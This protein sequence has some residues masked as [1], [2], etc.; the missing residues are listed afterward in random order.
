MRTIAWLA[1]VW[2]ALPLTPTVEAHRLPIKVYTTAN[3]MPRNSARCI[4]PDANGMLWICTSEGLVRFDGYQFRQFGPESGLPSRSIHDIVPS[5]KGGYWIVTDAGLCRLPEGSKIGQVCKPLEKPGQTGD[6]QSGGV[7][8]SPDGNVWIATQR[9]VFHVSADGRRLEPTPIVLPYERG[10]IRGFCQAP[11]GS[12]LVGTEFTIYR[13]NPGSMPEDISARF[14]GFE[15]VEQIVA[16]PDGNSLWMLSPHHLHRMSGFKSGAGQF[17]VDGFDLPPG[18][19]FSTMLFRRNGSLWLATPGISRVE[20]DPLGKVKEVER[21]T[22]Q[23]GLP[24]D[25]IDMLTED[26]QGNL[27]GVSGGYGVFRISDSGF[28]IHTAADGLVSDRIAAIFESKN[29]ELCILSSSVR[30]DPANLAV[31][32]GGRFETVRYG[33]PPGAMQSGWGWGQFGMQAHDGEWWFPSGDGLYRFASV[34]RARDLNGRM[35]EFYYDQKST[36]GATQIFRIFEDSRGDVWIS[37]LN[38]KNTLTQWKRSENAFHRWTRAE[39]WLGED[40]AAVEIRETHAGT[41]WAATD[42]AL[43]RLRGGRFEYIPAIPSSQVAYVR[44]MYV[45]R[46][47]RLWVATSRYG[48]FRCDDPEAANPVF[49]TYGPREGLSS[50]SVR[51]ITEDDAGYLYIGTVRG[52][53]RIDPNAPPGAYRIRHF[54]VAD[55]VPDSEQNVAFH[56]SRGRLWFGSLNGLAE[57]DPAKSR[58]LPPSLVY[59]TRLRVRGEEFPLP[60]QG[61]RRLSARLPSDKNQFEIQY[62][63]VDLRSVGSIRYQYRLAN[64][65]R[66]WS[67]PVEDISVNYASLPPG[68]YRFEVRALGTDG[69]TGGPATLELSIAA[70]LWRRWWF[71][72]LAGFALASALGAMYNY[73]VQ[74]LL[75]VERLRTRL[76]GDLHDDIGASLTQIAILT[77][78]ARRD[79]RRDVM[80][81]VAGIAREMVADMSDIVWAVQPN[82]DRFEALAHR[83]RRFA[84]DTLGDLEID[85]DASA[86]PAD[87]S[88]PLEYR[89]PLYLVFKE[90]ANNVS[91]HSGATRVQIRFLLDESESGEHQLKLIVEDNGKGFD[92]ALASNGA[93]DGEGLSSIQRRMREVGGAASW[94]LA[95]GGGTRFVAV[96]PLIPRGNLHKLRG[97]FAR[98]SR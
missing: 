7:I 84:S 95:P 75:A 70:P 87:F 4:A 37:A 98:P 65:D 89:R 34:A 77:E 47:G 27:W 26:L 68:D 31:E 17:A 50:N 45:D 32:N 56:D 29:G 90:A 12:I 36:L 24:Y 96:L 8:E 52:I 80:E 21:Y 1:I 86:L 38:P 76:A 30:G 57:F 60:W 33:R 67:E 3:G 49:R 20:I 23:E 61:V 71:L 69:Q 79:N 97:F 72:T 10:Y 92:F 15:G 25:E 64:A 14:P 66:D 81:D 54:T 19:K 13:W 62:A 2:A 85:F 59:I 35:P 46:A 41:V 73:R 39:G 48:L 58:A 74:N 88:V 53:D 78:L 22:T 6:F 11:D 43:F 83:M 5:R 55:G 63:A 44:D 51:A 16:A 93:R 42:E 82:H 91:R 28:K 40:N 94:T 9:A 18:R